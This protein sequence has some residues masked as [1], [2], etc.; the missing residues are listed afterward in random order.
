MIVDFL[1]IGIILLVIDIIFLSTILGPL[2]S[3][4]VSDI[5]GSPMKLNII[6]AVL[7]YTA[8]TIGIYRFGLKNIDPS[9]ILLSTLLGGGLF[10]LLTYG[11]FDFTNLAMFENY[12]LSNAL[13][14]TTWGGF[15]CFI[16][17]LLTY[18]TKTYFNL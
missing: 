1:I 5:Q 8:L 14:D 10:G 11:I 9:N 17:T 3:K 7:S 15:L 16:V 2:F 12:Q 6:S 4:M 18:Y 13:I